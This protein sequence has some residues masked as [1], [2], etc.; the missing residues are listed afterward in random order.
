MP[1]SFLPQHASKLHIL[2]SPAADDGN[3][4]GHWQS[5][6]RMP[7]LHATIDESVSSGVLEFR[8]QHNTSVVD[9]KYSSSS[10]FRCKEDDTRI[11]TVLTN[12]N[13]DVGRRRIEPQKFRM[14][15]G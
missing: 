13:S 10:G 11:A 15:I 1:S 9:L 4:S 5:L 7:N 3:C 12:S 2:S 14:Q 8:W 6:P